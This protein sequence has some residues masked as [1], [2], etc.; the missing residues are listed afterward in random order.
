MPM[1][2][3]LQKSMRATLFR[4]S[5]IVNDGYPSVAHL[6]ADGTGQSRG[7]HSDGTSSCLQRGPL[8]RRCQLPHDRVELRFDIPDPGR[9]RTSQIVPERPRKSNRP[10]DHPQPR[11]RLPGPPMPSQEGLAHNQVEESKKNRKKHWQET[12][13][14]KTQPPDPTSPRSRCWPGTATVCHE[15]GQPTCTVPLTPPGLDNLRAKGA[16]GHESARRREA[17]SISCT[18]CQGVAAKR[19]R[20]MSKSSPCRAT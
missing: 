12:S 20:G 15:A 16:P 6:S 1:G 5:N 19:R 3:I 9:P 8:Y 14:E 13:K 11:S 10:L 2:V 17:R 7:L 18:S 4:I